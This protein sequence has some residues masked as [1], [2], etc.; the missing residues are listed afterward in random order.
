[1][2][3]KRIRKKIDEHLMGDF[4]FRLLSS[5]KIVYIIAAE[6]KKFKAGDTKPVRVERVDIAPNSLISMCPYVRHPLGHMI[7]IG[8]KTPMPIDARRSAEY[9]LFTAGVDGEIQAGDLIGV[10]KVFPIERMR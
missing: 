3:F 10:V 5:G 6:G 4:D 7:A 2:R 8:E 9:A 1:M